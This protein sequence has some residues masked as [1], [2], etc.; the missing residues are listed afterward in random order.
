MSKNGDRGMGNRN[1]VCVSVMIL[2]LLLF[3]CGWIQ[4]A[5]PASEGADELMMFPATQGAQSLSMMVRTAHGKLIV[6]DG[7]W[8]SD[9]E[10][11]KEKIQAN[12]GTVDAW[13]L[14]H[15]HGDHAGALLKILQ[16]GNSGIQIKK[17]YASF[18]APEW[19]QTYAPDDPG[20][21]AELL[22]CFRQLPQ[23]T[24][25]D[26]IGKGTTIQVDDVQI[27]VM[28]DRGNITENAVNNNC[29][30]YK[31]MIRGK[32]V[33]I[34]GD[35]GYEGGEQLLQDAGAEAL[36]SDVVQMAHHG[37]GGVGKDVYEAISPE[38]C[39]WPTPQWLWDNDNGGGPGS[40]P[41]STPETR[42]WMEELQVR[43]NLCTKDGDIHMY[44]Q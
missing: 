33:L 23:G 44:F 32:S 16:E 22:D 36:K 43:E 34:L 8:D 29:I 3:C 6:I 30:V 12:G 17:I 7:G 2:L 19:Y 13:L 25:D 41:W 27:E 38:V 18:A 15:P 31:L 11:L 26:Q 37:Q 4:S 24:V 10:M 21:T 5:F 9:A 35:L 20:I 42:T 40:G 1:P 28:N 14:T 39:L